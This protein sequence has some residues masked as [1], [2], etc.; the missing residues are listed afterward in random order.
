V[1]VEFGIASFDGTLDGI[2]DF[3]SMDWDFLGGFD[4]ESNFV[5]SYLNDEYG[6]LVIDYNAFILFSC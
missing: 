1:R 4:S 2:V 6:D 5:P 3:P